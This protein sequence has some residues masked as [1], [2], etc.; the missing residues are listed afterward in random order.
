MTPAEER[1]MWSAARALHAR[2]ADRPRDSWGNKSRRT[3]EWPMLT[4]EEILARASAWSDREL[5]AVRGLGRTGVAW[6]RSQA[7]RDVVLERLERYA[8]PRA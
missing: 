6:L 5:R 4:D 7:Q 3:V 1:H 8:G 2:R